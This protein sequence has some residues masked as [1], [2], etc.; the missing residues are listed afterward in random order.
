MSLKSRWKT[1]STATQITLG[2]LSALA[3]LEIFFNI[4]EVTI[5]QIMLW[6]NDKRPKIGRLWT[7][8]ERDRTGQQQASTRI[9]SLR[10]RPVYE[11]YIHSFD[12]LVA[13][14]AFKT[15]FSLSRDEF[16]SLYRALPGEDAARL[17][18]PLILQ[19]FGQSNDWSSVK[20]TNQQDTLLILLLDPY[21]QPLFNTQVRLI[22]EEEMMQESH[23]DENPNYANRTLPAPLFISAFE[24]LPQNLRLQVINSPLKWQDWRQKLISAAIAPTVSHG[25]VLVALEITEAGSVVVHE[26]QASEL[27]VGYLVKAINQIN[28][29]QRYEVPSREQTHD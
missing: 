23:L 14:V 28:P 18:D 4:I 6:T 22:S 15:G 24:T 13:Y 9:D 12:D 17:I 11:R 1:L 5:G 2:V 10:M 3:I 21:G 19:E 26:M 16:L 25:S 29:D 8:E 27:A 7:E 20:M